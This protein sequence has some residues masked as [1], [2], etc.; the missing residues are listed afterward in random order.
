TAKAADAPLKAGQKQELT[1]QV[2]RLYGFK[3]SVELS[4]NPP[5]GVPGLSA[6]NVTLNKDQERGKL[7]IVSTDK[8]PPGQHVCTPRARGKCNNVQVETVLSVTVIIAQ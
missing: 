6:P 8:T 7:E 1:I 5:E 2:E 4:F 3:D